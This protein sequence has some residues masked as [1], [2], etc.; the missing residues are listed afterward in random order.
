MTDREKLIE[1]IRVPI[2]IMP[3]KTFSPTLTATMT[4]A[5]NLQTSFFPTVFAWNQSKRQA[6]KTSE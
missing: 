5:E 4:F 2:K 6:R 1:L 3:E